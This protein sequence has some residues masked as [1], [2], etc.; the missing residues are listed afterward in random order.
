MDE[1][2]TYY[3]KCHGIYHG[4]KMKKAVQYCI[5]SFLFLMMCSSAFAQ[6]K[7]VTGTVSD[8][9]GTLPG[10]TIKV[11]GAEAGTVTD[12]NGK[13]TLNVASRLWWWVTVRKRK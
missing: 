12:V 10:V 3:G 11:K 5:A 1:I 13:Y 7:P 2:F 6:S 9:A 8:N 4:V